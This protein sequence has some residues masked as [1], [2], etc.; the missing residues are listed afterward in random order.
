MAGV[1]L[2]QGTKEYLEIDV[3]DRTGQLTNLAGTSPE[4]RVLGTS[5]SEIYIDWTSVGLIVSNMKLFCLVD[6]TT[7]P[8]GQTSDGGLWPNKGQEKYRLYA[9]YHTGAEV[10][11]VGPNTFTVSDA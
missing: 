4:F 9:R 11:I 1:V 10:P 5:D 8:A 2:P 7:V 6:T 3:S